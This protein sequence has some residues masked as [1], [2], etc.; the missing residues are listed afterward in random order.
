VA[1]LRRHAAAALPAECC[2]AVIGVARDS[3]LE[4]RAII[5]LPNQAA[6]ADRYEID[7]A[8]VLRLERQATAAGVRLLGFYHS[9]PGGTPVPSATDLEL[10]CPGYIHLI[11][12][13]GDGAVR[14]WRLR[15]DRSGFLELPIRALLAGAA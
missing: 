7:A 4:V 11:V 8:T 6:A 3:H 2:G 1:G 5:P 13:T 12:A 9:H 14:G 15:D 10:A